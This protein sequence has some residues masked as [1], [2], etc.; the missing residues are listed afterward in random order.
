MIRV[1]IQAR[2]MA[3]AIQ[4]FSTGRSACGRTSPNTNRRPPAAP[5]PRDT[6]S[7][8]RSRDTPPITSRAV[9]TVS[10]NLRNLR[11]GSSMATLEDGVDERR[12]RRGLREE[13]QR[14][15][16]D[17]HEKDGR[18]PPLLACA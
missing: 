13:D 11:R 2:T 16:Q 14:A 1:L 15:Q 7:W 12:Q 9:P 10:P 5:S 8:P 4:A 6:D 18:E 3:R 17:Q